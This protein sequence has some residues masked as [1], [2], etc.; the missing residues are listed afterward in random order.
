M[1]LRGFLRSASAAS[2]AA[3]RGRQRLSNAAARA[4]ERVDRVVDRLDTEL[5]RDVQKIEQLQ[6][7]FH[8]KPTS[9]TG[10]KYDAA[11]D[12]WK[13]DTIHDDK[14]DIH[15]SFSI[16][17]TSDRIRFSAPIKETQRQYELKAICV[18]RWSLYAAFEV[19]RCAFEGRSTKLF[20][21]SDP[22]KN[23]VF[24]DVDG[25]KY[26]AIEGDLDIQLFGPTPATA[27]A[28][29]P[30]PTGTPYKTYIE[31]HFNSTSSP[32]RIAVAFDDR[33]L[34]Q[35]AAASPTLAEI[36]RGKL[37]S[38]VAT[39]RAQADETKS[40]IQRMVKS[41]SGCLLTIGAAFLG[42]SIPLGYLVF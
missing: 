30:L 39:V 8:S 19:S 5:E 7:R 32:S 34:F 13:F 4:H 11:R 38:K 35:K 9:A 27:I 14:G 18:T 23:R 16:E 40:E 33:A 15:W 2:R 21:K 12:E 37:E 36:I 22:S 26:Q 1:G 24:L 17:A 3:E 29:F 6:K 10:V 42:L 25:V 28:A 41:K 31:F 20:T